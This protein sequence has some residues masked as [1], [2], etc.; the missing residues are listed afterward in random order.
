MVAVAAVALAIAAGELGWRWIVYGRKAREHAYLASGHHVRP[1]MIRFASSLSFDGMR[2]RLEHGDP[3]LDSELHFAIV[4]VYHDRMRRKY[5]H[6]ATR[7]W[8]VVRPDPP[9]PWVPDW[10]PQRV[11]AFGP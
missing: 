5:E 3:L 6:A 10:G 2:R 7:P 1:E 4:V 9:M 8:V 11:E